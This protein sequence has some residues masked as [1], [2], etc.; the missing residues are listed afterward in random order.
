MKRI[1]KFIKICII[2]VISIFILDFILS[3]FLTIKAI[4]DLTGLKSVWFYG[5]DRF[6]KGWIIDTDAILQ[7]RYWGEIETSELQSYQK[8]PLPESYR[9]WEQENFKRRHLHGYY[10]QT[11]VRLN[12]K[13]YSYRFCIVDTASKKVILHLVEP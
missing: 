6:D 8:L 9:Q 1:I 4:K 7:A 5:A 11:Q 12:D 13:E 2:L 3:Y 10:K